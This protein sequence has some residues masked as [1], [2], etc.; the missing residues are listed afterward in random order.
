MEAVGNLLKAQLIKSVKECYIRELN[1]G[2]FIEYDDCSLLDILQHINDKYAK[3]DAHILKANLKVFE[4]DPLLDNPIDD[5][6][7]K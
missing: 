3:M 1:K 5:Y 2:D 4:E 7:T 6:F